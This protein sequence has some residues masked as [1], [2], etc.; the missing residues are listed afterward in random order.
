[1]IVNRLAES[2]DAGGTSSQTGNGRLNLDRAISD[3][4]TT[5][6]EPAG[7]GASGGLLDEAVGR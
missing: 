5:S 3:T 6:I 2:A 7:A 1:V 4:S